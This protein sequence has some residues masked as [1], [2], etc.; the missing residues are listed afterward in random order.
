[1][2]QPP[3]RNAKG[4]KNKK[5]FDVSQYFDTEAQVRKPPRPAIVE[6][7]KKRLKQVGWR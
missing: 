4:Q 6:P 2:L 7:P 3:K 1:M 5:D